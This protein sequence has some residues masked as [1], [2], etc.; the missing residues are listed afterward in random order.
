MYLIKNVRVYAPEALGVM[1]VLTGGEKILKIADHLPAESAYGVE[2]V[3]GSGKVLLPGLIDAHVHILGGGGEGG[4]RT[5][6]PE[7]MLSDIICGGVT[8]V[9]G[10][11]G[12]D[13]CTRTMTN[14]IAKAKGLTEEGITCYAYTGSY[15]V[16]VRT[17]T[18][19]IMDDLILLSEVVGTG[20]IAISDH[21][22]SQPTREEFARI[23]ADTRVGGILSGKAGLVNIH[24][25]DG[26]EKLGFLRYVLEHTQIPA[27]QMLPTHINRSRSLIEDGIDYAK[28]LGGYID[29]TTSSD[30]DHLEP[31]E[32]KAGSGLK[33]ALE[34][35]VPVDHIT[36]SSDGQG[37]LP[38]FGPDGT[39]LGLGVGKVISLYREIKD[40]VL[41][42]GL[43]LEA[44]LK[45]VTSNPASLLKLE[46]KGRIAEGADADLVLAD[47]ETLEI[48]SVFARG[49]LMV[50]GG[51]LLVKGTF[52][53]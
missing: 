1:D 19:S 11:L 30:P 2:T 8:T 46:R 53:S 26:E 34:A 29:L 38:V 10:C 50:S 12:T 20:E 40:A 43:P 27:S 25:G 15:Q 6:T 44:A 21:R 14:L 23:V 41:T 48:D 32:V 33:M 24:M 35:G 13:G 47:A 37:S 16:P 36:F 49:R 9:V 4:P 17:L 39:F 52:E 18:G 5:R 51:K 42:E 45:P 7:I 22:S 31:D 3:D 28:N